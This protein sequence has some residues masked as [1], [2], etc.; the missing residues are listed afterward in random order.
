[1]LTAGMTAENAGN[2]GGPLSRRFYAISTHSAKQL[3]DSPAACG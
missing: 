3:A 2:S 1:M